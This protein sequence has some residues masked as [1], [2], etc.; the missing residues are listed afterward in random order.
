[1]SRIAALAVLLVCAGC[2]EATSVGVATATRPG[3]AWVLEPPRLGVGQVAQLDRVVVTPPGFVPQPFAAPEALEGLWVLGAEV[4]P[5]EKRPER[6]IHRTRVRIRARATGEFVWPQRTLRVEGPDG[7]ESELSL[8]PLVIEV[9]SVLPE[10]PGRASPF[11]VRRPPA[12]PT[13]FWGPALAGALT[14]LAAFGVVWLA[15][16]RRRGV[17]PAE[18]V[19]PPA[20]AA[21][22]AR[23]EA[24]LE[25][26]A[27]LGRR[28]PLAAAHALSPALRR[29]VD[30]RFRA[31]TLGRTCE[32]L[33]ATEPPF[34]MRSR[35]PAFAAL[36]RELDAVRFL[37]EGSARSASSD[38][39]PD[40]LA[41]AR[42]FVEETIPPEQRP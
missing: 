20:T 18:D 1:M 41:R 3:A 37:P 30:E 25:R 4:L 35:W 27:T 26:A 34:A 12:E 5:V 31:D 19:P 40:W 29:Y 33:D 23:A 6:W 9:V 32:E 8:P 2:G 36:V 42:R 7:A 14:T 28:D 38:A 10:F 39:L 17:H 13:G 21:P 24:E 15:R 11:G 22:W 16:A